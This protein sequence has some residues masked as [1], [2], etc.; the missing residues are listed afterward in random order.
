M[1]LPLQSA[2]GLDVATIRPS[3]EAMCWGI[4]LSAFA[5]PLLVVLGLVS[6][7]WTGIV[8]GSL[9]NLV[10]VILVITAVHR[11]L[12]TLH[13]IGLRVGFQSQEPTPEE[14]QPVTQK[15]RGKGMTPEAESKRDSK[16]SLAFALGLTSAPRAP[17]KRP[18]QKEDQELGRSAPGPSERE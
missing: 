8:L 7:S 18:G 11:A 6:S 15:G 14:S 1:V 13:L 4:G 12:T 9:V 2:S 17:I 10:G 3:A 5:G 16:P